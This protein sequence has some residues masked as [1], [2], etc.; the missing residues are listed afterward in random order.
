MTT[1]SLKTY[2]ETEQ[3]RQTNKEKVFEVLK[4]ERNQSRFEIGRK[5]GLSDIESQRRL[6]DLVNDGK[7]VI[8]GSRKHFEHDVSLYSAKEQFSLFN[9]KPKSLKSWLKESHPE[10]LEQY[11][12]YCESCLF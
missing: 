4:T 9:T 3:L 5:S 6:S 2:A 8:T 7:A 1:N 10:T 11:K 12:I